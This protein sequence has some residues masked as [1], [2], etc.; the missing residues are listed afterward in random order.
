[1]V[2]QASHNAASE[3]HRDKQ[4]KETFL[5][6][7]STFLGRQS[8]ISGIHSTFLG[9]NLKKSAFLVI[10][11]SFGVPSVVSRSSLGKTRQGIREVKETAILINSTFG[12]LGVLISR[13]LE[14]LFL[15]SFL[16]F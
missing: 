10:W 7:E 6:N 14:R 16:G 4:R 5:G 2:R 13:V 12:W 9:L 3:R 11:S 1:M 8:T 15:W